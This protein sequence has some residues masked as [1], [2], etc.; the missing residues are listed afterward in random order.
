MMKFLRAMG[1]FFKF[2][3]FWMLFFMS[4]ELIVR[5]FFQHQKMYQASDAW[6]YGILVVNTLLIVL[7]LRNLSRAR[8]ARLPT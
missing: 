4:V 2:L 8:V 1:R 7:Y 3:Y 5:R 6:I